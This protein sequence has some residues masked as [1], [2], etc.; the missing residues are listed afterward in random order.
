MNTLSN[1]ITD[2]VHP[3]ARNIMKEL[4][5]AERHIKCLEAELSE[6][7]SAIC[8]WQKDFKSLSKASEE[9]RAQNLDLLKELAE[10][11][12]LRSLDAAPIEDEE[13]EGDYRIGEDRD[14]RDD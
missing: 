2:S 13:T 3:I 7:Y 10:V 14:G 5:D 6:A 4:Q 8:L 9:V 12:R 11:K 1:E